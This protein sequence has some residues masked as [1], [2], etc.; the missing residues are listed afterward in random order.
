MDQAVTYRIQV[1]GEIDP[2]WSDRLGG[3]TISTDFRPGEKAITTL[4]GNLR[5]QAALA[6]VM[7]TLHSLRL[8]VLAVGCLEDE[9]NETFDEA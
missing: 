1:R 8:V 6:G 9:V 4:E 2:R 3:M 7:N 5:D